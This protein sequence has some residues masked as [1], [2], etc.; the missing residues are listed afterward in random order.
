MSKRL[1][2]RRTPVSAVRNISCK[3]CSLLFLLASSLCNGQLAVNDEST[4]AFEVVSVKRATD[5]KERT[6]GPLFG[7]SVSPGSLAINCQTAEFL[8]RQAFLVH[9]ADPAQAPRQFLQTLTG[10]PGWVMSDLYRLDAKATKP[11]T[12]ERMLGPMLQAMLRERFRLQVHFD[13][14]DVSGFELV[15]DERHPT[16][17]IRSEKTCRPSDLEVRDAPRG[18]HLCGTLVRSLNPTV[19]SALYGASMADLCRALTVLL[20][21]PVTDGTHVDGSFDMML[22]LSREALFPRMRAVREV[23][24]G[25]GTIESDGGSVSSALSKLGLKLT[26]KRTVEQVLVVDHIERPSSN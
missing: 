4:P 26:S 8:I 15:V 1:M 22:E 9:G 10:L 23:E 11:T 16:K 25:L 20:E 6:D 18:A 21:R 14:H 13:P 19:P 12:R 5:C 3:G 24:G 7:V 2:T 17:L